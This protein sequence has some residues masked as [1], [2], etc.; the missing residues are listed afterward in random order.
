M[1]SDITI[2]KKNEVYA[3]VECEKHLAMEL[4][5]Y[6]T[7]FVPG[8][9]FVPAFRNKIWD[10][11]IRL[12]NLQTNQLYLGL[13]PYLKDFCEEREYSLELND[14]DIE[15]D[16]EPVTLKLIQKIMNIRYSFRSIKPIEFII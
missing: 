16:N 13:I 9:Q 6:F 4:S 15:D 8:H 5:E 14:T 11:K 12:F 3:K 7:F 10:G 1:A 2:T